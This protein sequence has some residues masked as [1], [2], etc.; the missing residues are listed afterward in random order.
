[1]ISSGTPTV[2]RRVVSALVWSLVALAGAAALGRVAL[3]RG[4]H[5]SAAWLLVAA[6][7]TYAVAYRFYSAF[8]A[9][10]VFALDD[11]RQTPSERLS[12]GRDYVPT[13]RWIVFGHHFAAIAGP[14]PLVGPTLAAQ[15]GY[16]PG[17][18][19]IIVG[20]VVG[21]AV[22][23]FV[24]LCASIRRDGKSLGQMAKE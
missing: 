8:I 7:C 15:F 23:D 4:E 24:I 13:N 2:R 14:G 19:W 10:R 17:I 5:I 11:A 3:G 20:V 18:L 22:Q 12:D 21:G 9:S 16:L 1:M 6:L